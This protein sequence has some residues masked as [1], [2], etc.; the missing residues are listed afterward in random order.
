MAKIRKI[1]IKRSVLF[2]ILKNNG[3]YF[4]SLKNQGSDAKVG[5]E[6]SNQSRPTSYLA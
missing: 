1:V 3:F 6:I 4:Y 2:S 5:G